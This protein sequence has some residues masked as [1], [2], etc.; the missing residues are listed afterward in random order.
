M[1]KFPEEVLVE[2]RQHLEEEKR[3]IAARMSE[4]SIQ[5]PFSDS[6]RTIDN[7]ASDAEASEESNHERVA[8]IMAELTTKGQELDEALLCIAKGTYGFCSRCGKMID[9]DRLAILPTAT[10]CLDCEKRKPRK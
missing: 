2:I 9:T 6:D 3:R 5:D 10:L 4:L 8:A 7:A 1:Q